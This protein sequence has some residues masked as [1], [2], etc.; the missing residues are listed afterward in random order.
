MAL[1][2]CVN[3]MSMSCMQPPKKSRLQT[4][5]QNHAFVLP[6]ASPFTIGKTV[7]VPGKL[8]SIDTSKSGDVVYLAGNL[9]LIISVPHGGERVPSDIPDRKGF[10]DGMVINRNNDVKTIEL[11]YDIINAIREKTHGKYPHV[12]IN[13]LSRTQIDQNRGWG[14]DCNPITGRG[15]QAWKD[16]HEH[17]IGDV[18][19]PEVLKTNHTGL[20]I[21]LHGKPDN[22][23]ADIMVGYNLT[24]TDLSN[25]DSKLNT[26]AKAYAEKS[27][28]RFLS[29]KL[30]AE[31]DF[32]GLLRGKSS[33]HENFGSLLQDGMDELNRTHKKKYS[34]SPRHDL[35]SPILNLSGGY[36]IQAFCGVRDD[37]IDNEYGYTD[38]RFISGFQLEVC[39][40]IRTKNPQIRMEFARKLAD[41]V[42]IFMSRIGIIERV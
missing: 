12:I 18:A 14:V 7:P 24:A 40:E 15:G 19:V 22:Y 4:K 29:K 21:D 28:I 39:R 8:Y 2:L 23:G 20:F 16:F 10:C 26:S 17:F 34:V 9:P 42:F 33:I 37:G 25:P 1:L 13:T 32:A 35:K 30:H 31:T 11:A 6:E 41:A 5:D 36:N 3:V 38:S 27:S